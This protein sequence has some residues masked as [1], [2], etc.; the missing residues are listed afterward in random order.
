[1]RRL[2]P[3]FTALSLLCGCSGTGASI[4]TAP[5]GG[6]LLYF[7][8]ERDTADS[9]LS[10]EAW[11][12]ETGEENLAWA[13][14]QALLDGPSGEGLSNPFPQGVEVRGLVVE[15]GILHLDLSE[16]YDG[17][18][19]VSLTLA[20][21][22]LTL[23]LCQLEGVEGLAIT[24]EGLSSEN[25]PATL[26]T[27][28]QILLQGGEEDLVEMTAA[29]WFPRS[30]GEGLGV[31]Y[32]PLYLTGEASLSRALLESLLA[33]PTYESLSPVLPAGTEVRGVTV[34]DGI[35]YVD[36]SAPFQEGLPEDES[37]LH[38]LIYSVVNTMA[39]NLDSIQAVQ[40]LVEGQRLAAR[41][42]L[43]L[44]RPLTPDASLE[45]S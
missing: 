40:I 6:Y 28:E 38:L 12:P 30:S 26:L 3:L 27:P 43:E 17:L 21:A 16:Q 19:G 5:A 25:T 11:T 33:G 32:R 13:A 45:K 34:E 29:L 15:D 8:D 41:D 14:V 44:E 31:E 9:A 4:P 35:C 42:G 2:I 1:M 39:G 37:T 18:S 20:N 22:C 10:A 23:T 7:L 36:F 24:V